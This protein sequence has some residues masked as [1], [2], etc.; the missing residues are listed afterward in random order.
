MRNISHRTVQN[1]SPKSQILPRRIWHKSEDTPNQMIIICIRKR[2][3]PKVCLHS[4][5][6][7]ATIGRGRRR[8]PASMLIWHPQRTVMLMAG[9]TPN[10]ADPWHNSYGGTSVFIRRKDVRLRKVLRVR[11][12]VRDR[13]WAV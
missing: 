13:F 12:R 8:R 11:G 1:D 2:A 4:C 10:M 7:R 5:G 9:H 3:R 6:S